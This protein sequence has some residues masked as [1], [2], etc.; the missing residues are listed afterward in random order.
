MSV[1][2]DRVAVR[3]GVTHKQVRKAGTAPR[4]TMKKLFDEIPCLRSG[5]LVL[6]QMEDRDAD[7]I[8]A[9]T[10][11]ERVYR[12]LPT[13]LF[14]KRYSEPREMLR[15]LYGECFSAG[16]SLI[17]GVCRREDDGLCGLAEFYGYKDAIRKV[18]VGYRLLESAWGQGIATEALG[19]MIDY[20]YGE[21]DIEIVTASTMIENLASANVLRKNGFSLVVHAVDEDWGYD[22]PTVAD[23]WI[24]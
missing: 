3:G 20:L 23:K 19:L 9:L 22:A 16:E 1:K 21:T 4:E 10:A 24:R 5:R 14:E 13:F 6:R 2:H 8:R 18:S 17:L 7:A 12:Y 15:R 11:S